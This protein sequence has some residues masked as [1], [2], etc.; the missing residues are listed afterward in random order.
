MAASPQ[1]I[2][3]T[4][5]PALDTVVLFVVP[6]GSTAE[7]S[8]FINNQSQAYDG[9]SIALVPNGQMQTPATQLAFL[10]QLAGGTTAAFSGLYLNS[11]DSVLVSSTLGSC[12]FT[13]TGLVFSS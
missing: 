9:Y 12:S 11:G 7:F 3:Q 8:I 6:N 5:P 1:I 4:K 13:A 10:T 2:G